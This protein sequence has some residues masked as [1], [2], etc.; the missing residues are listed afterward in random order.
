[1]IYNQFYSTN[2][3]SNLKKIINDDLNNQYNLQNVNI[4]VHLEKC[5]KYVKENVS[6]SPPKNMSVNKYLNLMNEKVYH[7]V[8]KVYENTSSG[9]GNGNKIDNGNNNISEQVYN[10][11]VKVESNKIQSTLFDNE[12]IKNYKNNENIIEYPKPSFQNNSGINTHAEKIKQE[13][14]LIYPKAEEIN[15]SLDTNENIKT[16]TVDLYND[17][18]VSYNEQNSSLNNF[19][20][21]QDTINNNVLNQLN[22]IEINNEMN[23]GNNE[24]NKLTPINKLNNIETFENKNKINDQILNKDEDS[25]YNFQNFL[26]QNNNEI[27]KDSQKIEKFENVGKMDNYS[28][29]EYNLN[30]NFNNG[31]DLGKNNLE[32][33]SLLSNLSNV[34]SK[35]PSFQQL[36]KKNYVVIDSRY[37]DFHLY[38]NQCEFVVKFSPS[39]NNFLFTTYYENEILIIRERNIAVGNQSSNDISETFDNVHSVYLDNV[40]TPVHSY[41]F[42]SSSFNDINSEELTLTIY[43]DSYLLLNI[44]EL[45]SP[46][47]GGNTVFKEAFAILRID[48]GSNLVGVSFSNNFTNLMVPKEIMIYEPTTLGKLDKFSLSLN[49]KNGKLYNFGI[50]KLYINNFS[51]GELKYIGLCGEKEYTTKFEINRNHSEYTKICKK[52]YNVNDCYILNNNSLVVRDLIY[53]Y[54]VVPNENELV[55]FEDEVKLDIFKKGA[56]SIKVSLSYKLNNKKTNVN[57]NNM[58]AS[59]KT[60]ND[61]ISN[62]YFILIISGTKYYL[63]IKNIDENFMYLNSYNQLPNFNKNNVKIGLSKGN[64]SGSNSENLDSFFYKCGFNVISVVNT[65]DEKENIDKFIIE[66]NYPFKNLPKFIQENNFSNDDLFIIQDKK[67][68]S[69]GFT[70]EHKIKDYEKLDSY[71]NESGNN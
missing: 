16:N 17:L 27:K 12:I 3:I 18:L 66:V 47:R 14:D 36:T 43:K 22:T 58:F 40:I 31:T 39:D 41:E 20:N 54:Y 42:S 48:Q 34:L 60:L 29:I 51:Q 9:N 38:P 32:F 62:Y 37:R 35:K 8:M 15:F 24:V 70:I 65:V 56:D 13:R 53:F 6:D 5:M 19:E 63:Q 30:S 50:D 59:F 4:N 11:K 64:K 49:N 61:E 7:L 33:S 55:F 23:N 25:I 68:I 45:R 67:Q 2:N 46:Y 21:N 57:I 26:Q 52:Y 28:K 44:P 71:L 69:Y 1:M 10:K